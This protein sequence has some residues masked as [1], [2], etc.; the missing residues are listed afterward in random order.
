LT[1]IAL[2]A[3]ATRSRPLRR[4][5]RW[6]VIAAPFLWLIFF[7]LVP[8]LIVFRL[9]F[10]TA[11]LSQPPYTPVFNLPDGPA[12]WLEK[13]RQLTT[14]NYE[15]VFSDDLYLR[16][17][18]SSLEIAAISTAL[19]LLIGYPIAY[20]MSR[21]PKSWRTTLLMLVILPF[22]TSFLIRVYA[23]MNILGT[24]GL[25]NQTLIFLG[26]IDQPLTILR[27]NIAVYIGIVYSYLPF[28]ILPL[29]AALERQDRTLLEAAADLGATP[30]RSF[31]RIT[32]PLSLPG[33]FAGC[34]LVF[35]PAVGEYVIPELLGGSRTLMIASTLWVEF[36]RNRDWPLAAAVTVLLILILVV[37]IVIFQ[38]L[39]RREIEGGG[40]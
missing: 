31:W 28:M 23:W 13:L 5:G 30:A 7:F 8:F 2:D 4:L 40:R 21:A 39:S 15:W 10:S 22:W 12:V 9:S 1:D 19:V 20:G 25:L 17:Y 24:E 6:L 14:F 36:D 26:V 34:F 37:P 33:V 35:I 18:L 11:A 3:P 38:N 27:T 16:A 32:F 29:Y